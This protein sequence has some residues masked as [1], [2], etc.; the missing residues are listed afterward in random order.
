[1]LTLKSHVLVAFW[2][3]QQSVHK[4]VHFVPKITKIIDLAKLF[5][6]SIMM[7]SRPDDLP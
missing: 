2:S 1:M 5:L 3:L 7:F 6:F 4:N